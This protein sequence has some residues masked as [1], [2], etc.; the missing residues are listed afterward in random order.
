MSPVTTSALGEALR[1]VMRRVPSPVTTVTAAACGEMRGITIGS[2][3]S[4]SLNPPLISFNVA[5]QARIHPLLLEARHFA[6]HILG[7]EQVALSRRFAEPGLSG[8]EQFE[9][10]AYRLHPEGTPLLEGV[11]AVLHCRPYRTLEAGDHTIFVGEVVNIETFADGP[12]LLYY[13]RAYRAV[14]EEL[15]SGMLL[16]SAA[17]NSAKS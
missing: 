7:A 11:L 16:N 5:R 6:V 14:G 8:A 4:V 13:N 3:T 2:F 9:E 15:A 1:Q 17:P 10:L 12:P